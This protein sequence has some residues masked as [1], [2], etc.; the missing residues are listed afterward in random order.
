VQKAWKAI[1]LR[2]GPDG[3][4]VDV[5]AGTGKQKSLQDYYERPAILGVDPRGGA[6]ALLFSTAMMRFEEPE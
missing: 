6:M 5:C 3:K 1:K 2:I 4:L